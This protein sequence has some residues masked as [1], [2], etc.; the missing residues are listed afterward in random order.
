MKKTI[1]API[2][3]MLNQILQAHRLYR[4]EEKNLQALAMKSTS[5]DP[6]SR[7]NVSEST[8]QNLLY[9]TALLQ[10]ARQ[11]MIEKHSSLVDPRVFSQL[12]SMEN[13]M[14]GF[15][16]GQCDPECYQLSIIHQ[17][18]SLMMDYFHDG[19]LID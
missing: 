14:L 2:Y 5:A 15:S 17:H 18:L 9:A 19:L 13:I 8:K 1:L 3:P 7:M 16:K 10:Q 12:K 6:V 4:E 11:E